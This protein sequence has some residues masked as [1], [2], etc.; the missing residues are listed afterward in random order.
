LESKVSELES[1][2]ETM[3]NAFIEFSDGLLE[4]RTV[5]PEL[6]KQTMR[7]FL[8]LSNRASRAIEEGAEP[9]GHEPEPQVD[10]SSSM[11]PIPRIEIAVVQ[12]ESRVLTRQKQ[13]SPSE[14]FAP[15]SATDMVSDPYRDHLW[16]SQCLRQRTKRMLYHIYLQAVIASP[17]DFI[18]RRWSWP[19]RCFKER[20]PGFCWTA[21]FAGRG[22]TQ[23]SSLG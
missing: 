11:L 6:N 7:K 9:T 1:A 23:S 5:D 12:E 2:V 18:S 19:S 8:G 4:S 3:S 13:D 17:Q 21:Y 22:D 10:S 14:G 20:V 15:P 16:G